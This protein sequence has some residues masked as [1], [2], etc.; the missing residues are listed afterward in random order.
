MC[1]LQN[2]T[3]THLSTQSVSHAL[4]H[5]TGHIQSVTNDRQ[6]AIY[7]D[8]LQL[9]ILQL[10]P[11]SCNLFHTFDIVRCNRQFIH[12]TVCVRVCVFSHRTEKRKTPAIP[13][14][15][16][17][18]TGLVIFTNDGVLV[19]SCKMHVHKFP[20]DIQSCTLTFKSVVHSCEPV[21]CFYEFFS[22]VYA[23]L[24]LNLKACNDFYCLFKLKKISYGPSLLTCKK[25][26]MPFLSPTAAE[27]IQLVQFKNSSKVTE[28]TRKLMD[29]QYEWLFINMTVKE[30]T[31]D[32]LGFIQSIIVYT[33]SV[34]RYRKL[35][36]FFLSFFFLSLFAY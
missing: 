11:K 24:C 9:N 25:N 5:T 10:Q 28:G 21:I 19:S 8:P 7:I 31:V 6:A 32:N 35:P 1:L 26:S 17:L 13:F 15:K 23:C 30:E 16:V 29:T 2:V 18:Y 27:E 14:L 3:C 4:T 34:Y 22:F 20:F 12:F 36:C 33:V